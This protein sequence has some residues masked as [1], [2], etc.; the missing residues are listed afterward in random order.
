[1]LG[2]AASLS[3][4]NMVAPRAPNIC[5]AQVAC[6]VGNF[7]IVEHLLSCGASKVVN[8]G[9]KQAG[10]TPLMLASAV[11]NYAIVEALIA[12]GAKANV[13]DVNGW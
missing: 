12:Q 5:S 10:L 9:S 4:S 1:M 13:A 11:G 8:S 6:S 2:N 3:Q 7:E